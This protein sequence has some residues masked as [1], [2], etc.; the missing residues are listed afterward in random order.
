LKNSTFV[1]FIVLITLGLCHIYGV[2]D[3][4]VQPSQNQSSMR[5]S[6]QHNAQSNAPIILTIPPHSNTVEIARR[7]V[8]AGVISQPW[9]FILAAFLGGAKSIDPG[10]YTF[11]PMI[12]GAE[13]LS[14]LKKP[15][16]YKIT[17]PEGLTVAEIARLLNEK[18]FLTGAIVKLPDEGMILPETYFVKYGDSR[19]AVLKRAGEAMKTLLATVA[20]DLSE[21]TVAWQ[22]GVKN[23][24]DVLT[25]ASII[26][27]ETGIV[28]ERSRIAGVF[29]NRLVKKMRLQSDPTVSYAITLGQQPLGRSLTKTDLTTASPINTYTTAGLPPKPIACPGKAALLAVMTHDQTDDL[30]FVADGTGGHRFSETLD[31]HNKNVGHWRRVKKT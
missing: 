8:N 17:I 3:E 18:K 4:V 30:Y 24:N 9:G 19:E 23:V 10:V 12:H 5:E 22:A 14:V 15:R 7:L 13:A 16:I 27:K 6:A 21:S 1:V 11:N 2:F 29:L 31:G 25:L 26:E 28:N 20:K